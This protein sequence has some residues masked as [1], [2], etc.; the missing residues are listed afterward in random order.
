MK[1]KLSPSFQ[2][3]AALKNPGNL[4]LA[5]KASTLIVAVTAL[6]FQDLRIIFTDALIN[7]ATSYILIM[8][9]LFAYLIY[10]KR[11]MLRA[12][13]AAERRDPSDNTKHFGALGGILLSATAIILYW[14]GSYTFTPL[15]YHVLTLPLFAAGLTLIL[16]N[17]QT[18]R[19]AA[20]PTV[21]LAFLVPLPSQ[22]IYNLG[23]TLSIISS[24][25]SNRIV[26]LLG[27]HSTISSISGTPAITVTQANGTVLPPFTVD[28]AC[29][30]I[31]SL[32]G[33]LVFA[34][35]VAFVVRD[36]L[37]KKAAIF[38]VGFPLIYFLNILRI[39]IIL[40][41]GYQ[42]GQ[43]LALNI[44]HL[45]GG[46]ILIFLGTL[47]LLVI[48]EKLF[49]TKIF[50]KKQT[51]Q[52]CPNCNPHPS[53]QTE[54]FCLTCGKLS[55]YPQTRPKKTDAP[56]IVA[57]ALATILL[58]SIQV[59]VFA[60]TQGPAQILIQ[61][62]TGQQG[63]TQIF[64]QI[65]NYALE[66]SYRDTEFEEL[67]K[68][69]YALIYSY[70]PENPE[71]EAIF[72]GLEIAPTTSGMHRWE[73]CLVDWPQISGYQSGVE[74]LDLKDVQVLQN[75]S[76][77]ARYFAFRD[78]SSNQTEVVL[79]WYENAI[80]TANGTSQQKYVEIS[81][82]AYPNT[83]QDVAT[84]ENELLPFATAIVNYWQ[85]IKMWAAIGIT[86]SSN[87][88]TLAEITIALLAAIIVFYTF[89]TMK[90]RRANARVY[91]K[92]SLQNRYIIDTVAET[93]K[94]KKP[95]LQAIADTFRRKIG[96]QIE[97]KDLLQK[98]SETEK[99]GVIESVTANVQ[100]E[101]TR[102][103]KTKMTPRNRGHKLLSML[104][105]K[106]TLSSR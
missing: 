3:L 103:W 104:K 93:E 94:T 87:G 12:T 14:Y 73:V 67:A 75:P 42:W 96:L 31:Y 54:D 26:N 80:F 33:F 63:N 71:K 51:Q 24:V 22:I 58:L 38:L 2:R 29:S 48:S 50:T 65:P 68:E 15:E 52:N 25:A 102:A 34:A 89:E 74:Q 66:Y 78:K 88:I 35:F 98:L 60:L 17:P 23:S 101:P 97:E 59:P 44:F 92:L 46:W 20:F 16:F 81:L 100:D 40:L 53:N 56:K 77:M 69:D 27:I 106:K 43:E 79:Y 30:G 41:I 11:R 57:I 19:Q 36:E 70:T 37:W 4:A 64:P 85:P 105:R 8:P 99:T 62:P 91:Q 82:I 9:F 18:L 90:Q 61:T 76:L 32:I 39:T 7:E 6:Y 13:I 86:L 84:V 83:P 10:R 1:T 28:I 49:K 55:K 5:L 47:I 95:T 21:F 72:V 45:L